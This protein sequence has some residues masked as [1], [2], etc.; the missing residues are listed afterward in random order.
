MLKARLTHTPVA[1]WRQPA[2]LSP[3]ES[4]ELAPPAGLRARL[5][6]ALAGVFEASEDENRR[7]ILDVIASGP[8]RERLLDLGCLNGAFTV[9]L[10]E[11]ARAHELVGVDWLPEHAD[12]ARARGIEV[13]ESDLNEPLPFAD[14]SF[15]LVHANQVIEHLRGTDR[16]LREIRRVCAPDGRIVLSTNNLASWH[17]VGSLA[18]GMQPFPAHVSDE[19]HVGNPLDPRRG[20]RHADI[21]QT[22]LRVFTTRALRELASVHGLRVTQARLNGYYPLPP[23]LARRAARLDPTHAAFIVLELAPTDERASS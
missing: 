3:V 20:R 23:V 4:P 14:A 1:A 12:L 22:H 21:G 6:G 5:S 15:D 8:P 9:D 11:A 16:F 7:V 10:G 18:L 13:V 19:V 2:P 17:N